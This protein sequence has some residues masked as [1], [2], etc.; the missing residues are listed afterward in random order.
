MFRCVIFLA[1]LILAGCATQVPDNDPYVAFARHYFELLQH[2]DNAAIEATFDAEL[3]S[4]PQFKSEDLKTLLSLIE[5]LVPS[6]PPLSSKV[7]EYRPS[8][9]DG[10]PVTS[11]TIEY[12]FPKAETRFEIV[13]RGSGQDIRVRHFDLH[14]DIELNGDET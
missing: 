9:L 12:Q 2:K 8:R 4:D 3:T 5:I 1:S 10:M 13:M 6:D 14:S 11:V 7:V